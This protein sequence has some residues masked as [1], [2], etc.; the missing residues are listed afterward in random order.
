MTQCEI[1]RDVLRKNI[2]TGFS[3]LGKGDMG[4][5]GVLGESMHQLILLE[6][7]IWKE[8]LPEEDKEIMKKMHI[9][10]E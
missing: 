5:R 2:E 9:I 8:K 3:L 4:I 1:E 7:Q 6:I 10:D